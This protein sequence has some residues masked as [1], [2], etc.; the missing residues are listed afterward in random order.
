MNLYLFSQ[1]ITLVLCALSAAIVTYLVM[2]IDP[3]FRYKGLPLVFVASIIF[4]VFLQWIT[5]W[6]TQSSDELPPK[7]WLMVLPFTFSLSLLVAIPIYR[8][9]FEGTKLKTHPH[10]QQAGI[11]LHRLAVISAVPTLLVSIALIEGVKHKTTHRQQIQII[12]HGLAVVSVVST[13]LLSMALINDYYH[14]Y[15]TL[16]SALNIGQS[17]AAFDSVNAQTALLSNQGN[18]AAYNKRSVEAAVDNTSKARTK[19]TLYSITIPGTKSGFKARP[20]WVYIPAIATK[21]LNKLNLPVLVLLPGDPGSPEDWINGGDLVST[22][23]SFAAS[24]QGITPLV[25]VVDDT[26]ATFNDTECVNSPRG[27]VEAYLTE[28]VPSYIK[29]HLAVSTS[30]SNWAIGGISMGGTCSVMLALRHP[31]IYSYFIDIGGEAYTEIGSAKRTIKTLFGGSEKAWAVHQPALILK[32]QKFKN[33]GGF[34]AS[35]RQD[36]PLVTQGTKELYDLSKKAGLDAVYESTNGD[37]TF[38]LFSPDFKT[39]LPWISNRIGATECTGGE[40]Y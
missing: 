32:S 16:Y 22:M 1:G 26:G 25:V 13:L 37:H 39:A 18:Q 3:K 35:G 27:N 20:G 17:K 28:D 19:G 11:I 40:C 5:G 6:A 38:S 10:N 2:H 8:R 34:F 29:S 30:P 7:F 15:P 24:H 14:L 31:N 9:F 12:L 36:T 23:D 33:V 21:T 4:A